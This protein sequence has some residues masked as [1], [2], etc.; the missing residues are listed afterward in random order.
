MACDSGRDSTGSDAK[1]IN[2][3][4]PFADDRFT[5]QRIASFV[6]FS[7]G[8]LAVEVFAETVVVVV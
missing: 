1:P 8:A 3:F 5:P 6:R 4:M 2:F 7:I